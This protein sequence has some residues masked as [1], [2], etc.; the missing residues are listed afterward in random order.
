MDMDDLHFYTTF[1]S[2]SEALYDQ[3]QQKTHIFEFES[4]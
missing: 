2:I 4:E 1:M 3:K